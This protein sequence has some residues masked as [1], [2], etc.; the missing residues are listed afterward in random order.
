ML[1]RVE[2]GEGW[3]GGEVIFIPGKPGVAVEATDEDG[4]YLA[5]SVSAKDGGN[6]GAFSVLVSCVSLPIIQ[7]RRTNEDT[8]CTLRCFSW[9]LRNS[10]KVV[11][12]FFV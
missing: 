10:E 8:C 5:T 11:R 6:S 7:Y 9:L 2:Y 4:G 1:G 12:V 3:I